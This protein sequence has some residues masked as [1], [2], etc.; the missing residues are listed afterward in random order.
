MLDAGVQ[1]DR[2]ERDDRWI[3][4][5]H[6]EVMDAEVEISSLLLETQMSIGEFLWLRVGDVIPLNLPELT[7]VF[8][9]DV[10][11]FRGRYGQSNGRYAV[12]FK[13]QVRRREMR[14]L[15]DFSQEKVP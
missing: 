12:R 9:E 8:A 6:E 15:L 14:A 2:V 10:P 4:C 13:S 1:S 5:L 7:T 11:V 3:N